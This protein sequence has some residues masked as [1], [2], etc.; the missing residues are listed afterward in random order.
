MEGIILASE[1]REVLRAQFPAL[2]FI[3]CFDR[4]YYLP[5]T[6]QLKEAIK[7]AAAALPTGEEYRGE[8]S[9]CDEFA[10]FTHAAIKRVV[11]AEAP[12]SWAYG[13]CSYFEAFGGVHNAC[14]LVAS[15]H[16]VYLHEPRTGE[17]YRAT[18]QNVYWVRF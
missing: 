14:I 10:L 5:T 15:D 1:L 16:A 3:W 13:E 2:R 12:T 8:A 9:D 6:A 17:V 18:D 11:V 7:T 4:R